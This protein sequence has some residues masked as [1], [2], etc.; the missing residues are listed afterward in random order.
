VKA[1][2]VVGV[3]MF[4]VCT[5]ATLVEYQPTVEDLE[6][7][8]T[9]GK[10]IALTKMAP[11]LDEIKVEKAM[12]SRDVEIRE[13]RNVPVM[14]AELVTEPV[15]VEPPNPDDMGVEKAVDSRRVEAEEVRN[16]PE[17]LTRPVRIEPVN[18]AD[19]DSNQKPG[20]IE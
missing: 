8:S 7:A 14:A 15:R 11:D 20:I 9:D 6:V 16:V 18:P 1:F 13:V 5:G 17:L 10:M 19:L 12:N 4:V 2:L 3:L